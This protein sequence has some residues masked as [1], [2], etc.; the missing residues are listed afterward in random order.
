MTIK[1]GELHAIKAEEKLIYIEVLM[2]N[3]EKD[4]VERILFDWQDIIKN[5]L[6]I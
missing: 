6:T 1:K 4:D 5:C 2:G 3:L